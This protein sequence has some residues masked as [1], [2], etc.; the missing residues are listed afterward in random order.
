MA[1]VRSILSQSAFF[2]RAIG[3]F[4]FLR[5]YQKRP[6]FAFTNVKNVKSCFGKYYFYPSTI[7]FY[8]LNAFVLIINVLLIY[9]IY[10]PTLK[11]ITR[12]GTLV[13]Y[14][15]RISGT[16][17]YDS[18]GRHTILRKCPPTTDDNA[19]IAAIFFCG[20]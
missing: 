4:F 5:N 13:R 7:L 16:C 10:I 18:H 14:L 12:T 6:F 1:I 2:L 19:D 17:P 8:L 20:S 9:N 11:R 15:S 3:C